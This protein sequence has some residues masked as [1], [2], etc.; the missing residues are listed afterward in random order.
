MFVRGAGNRYFGTNVP[1]LNVSEGVKAGKQGRGFGKE[2]KSAKDSGKENV[3]ESVPVEK[4]MVLR[5]EEVGVEFVESSSDFV[6]RV[7]KGKEKA[8]GE[9]GY[10][11]VHGESAKASGKENV[12][13]PVP[14]GKVIVPRKKKVRVGSIESFYDFVARVAKGKEKADGEKG[15]VGVQEEVFIPIQKS[16]DVNEPGMGGNI[17]IVAIEVPSIQQNVSSLDVVEGSTVKNKGGRDLRGDV[18]WAMR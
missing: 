9:E 13:E 5:E 14:V 10:V 6:V 7:A 8:G 16:K 3:P 11:G 4:V 17:D 1:N 2:K 18:G 15:C 12:S